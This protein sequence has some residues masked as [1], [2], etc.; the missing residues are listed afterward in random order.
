MSSTAARR[1]K[2]KMKRDIVKNI[3]GEERNLKIPTEQDIQEYIDNM[4]K[5]IKTDSNVQL[6]ETTKD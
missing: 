3:Q 5:E 6:Q 4:L 1:M 2:R